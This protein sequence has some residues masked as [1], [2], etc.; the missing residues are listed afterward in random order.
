MG[1]ASLSC[2]GETLP[3][4]FLE[5]WVLKPFCPILSMFPEPSGQDLCCR[6][7]SRGWVPRINYSLYFDQ[8]C[9]SVI[10]SV[11]CQEKFLWGGVSVL[12][13]SVVEG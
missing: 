1:E 9:F 11:C 8:L 4:D 6:S 2:L 7:V 13:F 12:L 5:L 3:A 10:I